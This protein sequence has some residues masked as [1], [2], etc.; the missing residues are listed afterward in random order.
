MPGT[1]QRFDAVLE[2]EPR[3]EHPPAE[4][5]KY[6]AR[7]LRAGIYAREIEHRKKKRNSYRSV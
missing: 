5:L 6:E 7:V 1:R 2:S 4:R 3:G